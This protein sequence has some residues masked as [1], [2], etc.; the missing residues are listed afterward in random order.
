MGFYEFTQ[1]NTGGVFEIND[2]VC[3]RL[4]IEANSADEANEIAKGLGVYFD[5]CS[6]GLDCSCCGDRWY[7]VY[8]EVNL[9]NIRKKGYTVCV[10]GEGD[11]EIKWRDKYGTYKVLEEPTRKNGGFRRFEGK[12]Y[13]ENIEEYAQF[14]AVEY[15]WT[16]PECRIYYSDGTVKEIFK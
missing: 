14:L 2:K 16:T 8:Q 9:E 11:A 7:E 4:F 1:N 15:G 3:H 5:G 6:K 12:I 10:F 13:F